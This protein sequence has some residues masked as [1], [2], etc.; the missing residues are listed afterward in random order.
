[1]RTMA[2]VLGLAL[3]TQAHLASRRGTACGAFGEDQATPP[4]GLADGAWKSLLRPASEG[5][6]GWPPCTLDDEQAMRV[7]TGQRLYPAA[8]GTADAEDRI[9]RIRAMS[10]DGALLGLLEFEPAKD[11]YRPVKVFTTKAELDAAR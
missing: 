3:G 6:T 9:P 7:A 8:I 4:D 1:V 11:T 5:L 2:F 10:S